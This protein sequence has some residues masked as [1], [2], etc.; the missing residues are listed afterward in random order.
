[1]SLVEA[2]GA[3]VA[4]VAGVGGSFLLG[5]NSREALQFGAVCALGA[6]LGDAALTGLGM[7]TKIETY[8]TDYQSYID[9]L[10]F[11]GA[12]VGAGVL[13]YSLGMQGSMLLK[14]VGIAAVAG[15]S[16]PKLATYVLSMGKKNDPPPA[17]AGSMP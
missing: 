16:A 1:M 10:D 2:K 3:A 11:L 5:F 17:G 12:A 13:N 14:T 9:P 8:L 6:S 7:D 15:G 4:L